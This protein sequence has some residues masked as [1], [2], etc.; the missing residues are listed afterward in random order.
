MVILRKYIKIWRRGFRGKIHCSG[1]K[2]TKLRVVSEKWKMSVEVKTEYNEVR[3][4]AFA[5]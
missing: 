2:L 5:S 3:K 1:K 4:T